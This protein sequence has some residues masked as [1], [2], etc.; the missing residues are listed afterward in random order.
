VHSR[1]CR[2]LADV[3]V[4]GRPVL[5]RLSVRRLFCE[6][7]GC[8]RRTFAEQVEVLTVR[9]QRRSPLLQHLVETAGVLLAGR[10]G[11]RLLKIL[12]TPLSRT[13]VLF[14][15]MRMP[16]P[17]APTPRVL[18]V[19]DFALYADTYGTLLVDAESRL[20][21]ALWSGRDAEQLASWLPAHPGVRVVCRDGSLVYRQA[22]PRV[23]R[24]RYRSVIAFSAP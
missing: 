21:I 20:P 23:L 3:A 2:T 22:S 8:A 6:A 18:G 16:L 11:A 17:L 5:I 10:G 9:Y 19:D 14:H 1:Y 13:A 7:P 12:K 15:V 4:G 24:R